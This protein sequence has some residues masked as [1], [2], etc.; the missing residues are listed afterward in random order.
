MDEFLKVTR[1]FLSSATAVLKNYSLLNSDN[2]TDQLYKIWPKWVLQG[3]LTALMDNQQT[4]VDAVKQGDQNQILNS[5]AIS[6]YGSQ[7][8]QSVQSQ[9]WEPCIFTATLCEEVITT[10]HPYTPG[11]D[12][13]R[14][15]HFPGVQFISI[16]FDSRTRTNDQDYVT[17]FKD[18]TYSS[19]WGEERYSGKCENFPGGKE[20]RMR[21]VD[22]G[23][24]TILSQ[25]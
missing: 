2:A 9:P 3:V 12:L 7:V 18:E 8:A 19:Y 10:S 16:S 5:I 25:L 15:L 17:I 4:C 11:E 20:A 21:S 24:G 1:C 23:K 13:Y 22:Q 6:A 14:T